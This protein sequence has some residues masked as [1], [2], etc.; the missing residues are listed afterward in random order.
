MQDV[1]VFRDFIKKIKDMSGLLPKYIVELSLKWVLDIIHSALNENQLSLDAKDLE[2]ALEFNGVYESLRNKARGCEISAID[3]SRSSTPLYFVARGA[4]D[5]C[6]AEMRCATARQRD[7]MPVASEARIM[8]GAARFAQLCG[9][10]ALGLGDT[11]TKVR[12]T[13]YGRFSDLVKEAGSF[14]L[15]ANNYLP[16][17]FDG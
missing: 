1:V 6:L 4:I 17:R 8:L 10:T 2:A 9:Q 16:N 13:D 11:A 3:W 5:V 7:K 15:A 14:V 12:K